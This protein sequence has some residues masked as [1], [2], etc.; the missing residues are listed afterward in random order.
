MTFAP[1]LP[2]LESCD[3]WVRKHALNKTEAELLI[4]YAAPK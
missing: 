4:M 3:S 1:N 2:T